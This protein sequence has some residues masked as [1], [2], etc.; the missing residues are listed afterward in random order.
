MI[1]CIG[2][3]HLCGILAVVLLTTP[4]IA[5]SPERPAISL[6][7]D[8]IHGGS[9][10][11]A[12][13]VADTMIL[14][15]PAGSG[16]PYIG[17]FESGW[18]GWTSID[19]TQPTV[20]H[21]QV[22]DYNQTVVGNLAAWCGEI[23]I[24]SCNDSLDA[25]GGYGNSWHD[26]LA[27]RIPVSDVT[28]NATVNVVATV[29]HD[30]EGG[31]DWTRFSVKI[32]GQLGFT[33]IISY[34]GTGTTA[35]NQSFTY[36]PSELIGGTDIYVVFRVQSDGGWADTD[37]SYYSAGACQIDE[38]TV[39]TSQVGQPDIISYTDFQDGS[40]GDWFVA[41]PD[42]VGDYAQLWTGLKDVDP[43]VSNYSQQVA[44]IDDGV[45]VPGTGGS[46]CINW[47]YGPGGYIVNTTGGLAGP[48]SRITN[49][50]LSP[51]MDWPDVTSDGM[52]FNFDTY[53][54]EDLSNDAPGIFFT[55]GVR[56]A[57]TDNSA[58]NGVQIITDQKF[59]DRNFVYY[60][61]PD[62]IRSGDNVTDLLN[63]GRDVIQVRMGIYEYYWGGWFGNDGYP[64]PYFDNVSVKI[65]PHIGPGMTT[66]ELDLA[67]DNFPESDTIDLAD[68]SSLHVRF[69][70]ANNISP[71]KHL[72]N[73]PGDSLVVDI[74]PIRAGSVLSGV[75]EMHYVI[76][77]NPVFD[78]Y[79]TTA[80]SGVV[81]AVPV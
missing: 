64:A 43:C 16:A 71:A 73:D 26:I 3:R 76:N 18:N 62:Y 6:G 39:T 9:T 72:R 15:G 81:P 77:A 61:G 25:P 75:P 13:T 2:R 37:C 10:S 52:I 30:T 41:F 46:K 40:F 60:G 57:D 31:Y 56:S 67:Q 32:E 50:I 21:W 11:L 33:N 49:D 20:H 29:Q 68:L 58:G 70:M 12:K 53:R 17:D 79:R 4:V 22:S 74:T 8:V 19:I 47:C 48:A 65:F 5:G 28:A 38:I 35:F 14:M 51:V 69:D 24:P 7:G 44:F 63:P 55:W 54:H 42:G 36:L 45:V 59:F 80:V 66:R 78:E 27:Y 23:D 1:A 34:D